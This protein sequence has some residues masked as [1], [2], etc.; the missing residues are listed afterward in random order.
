MVRGELARLCPNGCKAVLYY[1]D[2]MVHENFAD[3]NTI[4]G[5][6]LYNKAGRGM[7]GHINRPR[8]AEEFTQA[9]KAGKFDLLVYSSQFTEKEQPYDGLLSQLLCARNKPLSIISDNREDARRAGHSP[10]RGRITRRA[11]Q[12]HSHRRKGSFG[13]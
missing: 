11:D 6:A 7:I 13:G 4:Y 1:E 2:E 12:L 10:L 5:E 9:L 8:N 3:H